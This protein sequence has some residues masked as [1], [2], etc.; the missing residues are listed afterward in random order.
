MKTIAKNLLVLATILVTG[1]ALV[2]K[3]LFASVPLGETLYLVDSTLKEAQDHISKPFQV[4]IDPV[5]G[6]ANLREL[7]TIPLNMVQAM[8]C[9]PDGKTLWVIDRYKETS[10]G[11]SDG[12]G[13]GQLAHWDVGSA[14]GWVIGPEVMYD[15]HILQDVVLAAFSPAGT[16]FVAS[17][18]E[19]EVFTVNTS[20]GAATLVGHITYGGNQVDLAGADL[21][22]TA[23]GDAYIW[24][25]LAGTGAPA[26]FYDLELS[27]TTTGDIPATYIGGAPHGE[28][29][30][31]I[32]I[33]A[34]GY[35]NLAGSSTDKVGLTPGTIHEQS[36]ATAQDVGNSP[37]TMYLVSNGVS[38][39]YNYTLGDMSNG[40][41]GQLCTRTIGYY[42]THDWYYG[43]SPDYPAT[44]TIC[45][46]GITQYGS[47]TAEAGQDFLNGVGY[48][49]KPNGTD[50]SMLF[51]QLIAAKLNTGDADTPMISEVDT[52]L[53][54]QGVEN[55]GQLDFHMQFT[56]E[57]QA[58]TANY[59]ASVLDTFNNQYENNCDGFPAL[60]IQ[61]QLHTGGH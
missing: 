26:G 51:A 4:Y 37:Y 21:A 38:T 56:S 31:G 46:V 10:P 25:N 36:L 6:R 44:V 15:G 17:G 59:Y 34:N 58:Q 20:T 24:T 1:L 3:S 61:R 13:T 2:P 45:G 32:A 55:N 57:A 43:G 8:A 33:R 16:L 35:G 47:G 53:C 40:A 12:L 27:E 22:F 42:K 50:F 29:F 28:Y 41:L 49:S 23:S 11:V 39:P 14:S 48:A 5:A 9:T 54:A 30:T 60:N 19:N 7:P 52:W 18:V